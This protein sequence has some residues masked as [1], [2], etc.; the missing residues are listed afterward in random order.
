MFRMVLV[1]FFSR[2]VEKKAEFRLENFL[3]LLCFLE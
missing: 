1:L 2:M 3:E